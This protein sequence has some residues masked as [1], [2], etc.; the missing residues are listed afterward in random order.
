MTL[1]KTKLLDVTSVTGV[2]TVGIFNQLEL[3][4]LQLEHPALL[5]L[6]VS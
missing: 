2:T 1:K 5:T 6:R 3:M 4:Q